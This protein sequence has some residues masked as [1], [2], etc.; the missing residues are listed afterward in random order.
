MSYL[1]QLTSLLLLLITAQLVLAQDTTPLEQYIG[2]ALESNIA[3]QQQ[4]LSYESS[5]AALEEA[6]AMFFPTLSIQA[7]YSLARGGR[8]FTIPVGD[9][10]NPIYQNLNLINQMAQDANPNYPD[11]PAYPMIDNV[12]ENFLRESEQETVL[13]VQMPIFNSAILH[14]QRIRGNLAEADRI[15]VTVYKREL[16]KEVKQAY[17]RYAQ[18]QQGVKILEEALGLV[19]E[20]LRTAESLERNH[21]ATFDV[22]YSA[23][24]EVQEVEQQLAEAQKNE[25]TAK[26]YFNFLL[27]KGLDDPITLREADEY[28]VAITSLDAARQQALQLREELQQFNFY[29]AANDQQIKLNKGSRLPQVNLQ[30]DYGVQGVDYNIDADSDFFLG[31]VVMSWSLFDHATSARVQK[32]RIERDRVVRKRQEVQQQIALQTVQAHYELEAARKKITAAQAEV[33]AAQQAFRLVHKR[34]EQGQANLVTFTNARTQLTNAKLNYSIAIYSY[35]EQLADYERI[36]AG[37]KF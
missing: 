16:V 5:L 27:N 32:A 31:S 25:Q 34:F 22:V 14:N 13:R 9:L 3:L 36:T 21:K 20:N 12:E 26:A 23:Q 33:D 15:G 28:E 2:Q 7:R 18:A 17:F 29:E 8:A 19:K 4:Q 24:A 10:V 11:I 37:Y 6:R 1:K 30:A 35:Q